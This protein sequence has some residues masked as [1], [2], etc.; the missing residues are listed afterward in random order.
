M[1]EQ[2]IPDP[3][4]DPGIA[5]VLGSAFLGVYAHG[6]FICEL[7]RQGIFPGKVAGSSAGALAGGF[8]AAG[9]RGQ[10][11]EAATLS[12]AL[13]RAYP[14]WLIP[15][16]GAPL[17]IGVLTGMMNG[18]KVVEHLKRELP[19]A[20]IEDAPGVRLQIAV[21]D[22]RKSTGEFLSEGPLAEAIMASCAVPILFT[23][24]HL[25]GRVFH[26]GGIL[27]GV[28]LEPYIA[29]PAVHTIIVHDISYPRQSAAADKRLGIKEVFINGHH[30]LNDALTE[31]RIREAERNHKRVIFLETH[32]P[33]PG[34]FQSAKKK[35][36]YFIDGA[37]TASAV[38]QYFSS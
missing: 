14:D 30:M 23:G 29:D 28:P 2:P 9:L 18:K 16:R 7:N 24:Q 11:L 5:L 32:H 37:R 22:L 35:K 3:T 15:I 17:G 27:H 31:H 36:R 13:K 19:V 8:Y 21:T 26:D 34:F 10:E 6:G 4:P 12:G 38:S 1:I 33:S 20:N 25:E